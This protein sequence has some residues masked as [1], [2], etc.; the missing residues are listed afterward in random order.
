VVVLGNGEF[1]DSY[2]RRRKWRTPQ[3]VKEGGHASRTTFFVKEL[4]MTAFVREWHTTWWP[5]FG[6]RKG[7]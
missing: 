7:V 3:F 5:G 4:D 6:R 1:D 2:R